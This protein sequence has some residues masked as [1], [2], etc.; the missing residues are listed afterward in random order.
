[1]CWLSAIMNSTESRNAWHRGLH[2][3]GY[4]WNTRYEPNSQSL[5][6]HG[7]VW[8]LDA[9]FRIVLH[10]EPP[11]KTGPPCFSNQRPDVWDAHMM[12]LPLSRVSTFSASAHD[13]F[14]CEPPLGHWAQRK[15]RDNA[16]QNQQCIER[17]LLVLGEIF[18]HSLKRPLQRVTDEK[19]TPGSWIN[20]S[21]NCMLIRMLLLA[22]TD[23]RTIL[24]M[25]NSGIGAATLERCTSRRKQDFLTGI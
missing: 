6:S 4:W 18:I 10:E 2:A 13:S 21:T 12:M 19:E 23:L 1:M 9:L 17:G 5:E 7:N 24:G 25:L 3:A 20:F 11:V 15:S 14:G 8:V 16:F 22:K